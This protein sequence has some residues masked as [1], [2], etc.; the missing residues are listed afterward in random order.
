[1][2]AD[3]KTTCLGGSRHLTALHGPISDES[4][5]TRTLVLKV[6]SSRGPHPRPL[7]AE[8]EP[9][10]CAIV[11]YKNKATLI[12]RAYYRELIFTDNLSS[13]RSKSSGAA[14]QAKF[15]VALMHV[16]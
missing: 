16:K 12:C 5:T 14:L 9:G 13:N 6:I 2:A 3:A 8:L 7:L 4:L 15:G 11:L 10:N 1:M